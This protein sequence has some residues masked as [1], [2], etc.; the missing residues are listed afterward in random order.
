L[1][2]PLRRHTTSPPRDGTESPKRQ[3]AS[4]SCFRPTYEEDGKNEV[5]ASRYLLGMPV[6]TRSS[7]WCSSRRVVL[8]LHP[9]STSSLNSHGRTHIGRSRL[10]CRPWWREAGKFNY[11]RDIMRTFT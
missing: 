6:F 8:S 3:F 4:C 5:I 2:R 1:K 11:S 7:S 10:S 9:L